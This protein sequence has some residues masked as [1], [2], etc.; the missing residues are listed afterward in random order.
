MQFSA[1]L[2]ALQIEPHG[3]RTLEQQ[4]EL[5]VK[6]KERGFLATAYSSGNKLQCDGAFAGA[7]RADDQ[8]AGT[9]LDTAAQQGV[10]A[11][12]IAGGLFTLET[13]TV[14]GRDETR[15]NPDAAG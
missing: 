5:F 11:C 14:F 15:K 10:Q 1:I 4:P 6:D 12:D 8:R 2:H 13:G 9:L 3:E 7:G